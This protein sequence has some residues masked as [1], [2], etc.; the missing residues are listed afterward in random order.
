[1]K[2]R[3]IQ[4]DTEP[5]KARIPG[6]PAVAAQEPPTTLPGGEQSVRD[7]RVADG[8]ETKPKAETS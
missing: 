8:P 1:M 7:A 4:D 5:E 3:V 2:T 6:M